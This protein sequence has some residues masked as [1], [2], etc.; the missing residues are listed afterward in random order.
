MRA[1]GRGK[2]EVPRE[3]LYGE[4]WA[5]PVQIVARRYGLSGRGL[6]KL[7]RRER[8]PVPPRGH[9]AR[10]RA[11]HASTKTPLPVVAGASDVALPSR[12]RTPASAEAPLFSPAVAA[13]LEKLAAHR[14][15][16]M[17]TSLRGAKQV[18]QQAVAA[19][20]ERHRKR[21]R[22]RGHVWHDMSKAPEVSSALER[23]ALLL[24]DAIVREFAG[25]DIE[26]EHWPGRVGACGSLFGIAF[27]VRIREGLRR[28]NR[29]GKR[30]RLTTEY[31]FVHRGKL[32]IRIDLGKVR[33]AKFW[34]DGGTPIEQRVRELLPEVLR[35][36]DLKLREAA[37]WEV[38]C[39]RAAEERRRLD[40]IEARERDAASRKERLLDEA[41][42]WQRSR[43]IREYAAA[44]EQELMRH[45][46]APGMPEHLAQWRG[47]T[48]VVLA[49]M[50][51][52]PRRIATELA[53][54]VSAVRVAPTCTTSHSPPVTLGATYRLT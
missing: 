2:V 28:K 17:H 35:C 23:R 8:I 15:A 44:I 6:G 50:D 31:D 33:E 9:W 16:E 10:Q 1:P 42:R 5:E 14:P 4:V 40:A 20:A 46:A 7:C 37:E 29:I 12:P 47:W 22:R 21:R 53:A 25:Q 19:L 13:M 11:G 30:R 38:A 3:Q 27:R 18:T 39:Q 54:A 41:L 32:E 43:A 49:E 26:L 51:P 24:L 36:V 48:A 52:F 34:T 45:D